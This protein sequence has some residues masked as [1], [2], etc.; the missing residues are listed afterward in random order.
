MPKPLC[1][2]AMPFGKKLAEG[3][4]IDFDAVL[5][6]IIV[7]A[8]KAA[9]MCPLRADEEQAGGIIHKHMFERLLLCE[10]VICDLTFANANVFY[11]LGVRHAAK[12]F[13][14][15]LIAADAVRLPF[16]VAMMRTLPYSL[17]ESGVPANPDGDANKLSGLLTKFRRKSMTDIPAND[18]PLFQLLDDIKPLQVSSDKTDLF[19]EQVACTEHV[20]SRLAAARR[21]GKPALDE[22]RNSIGSM[23][24][25]ES[26]VAIDIMLSYRAI[27]DWQGMIDFIKDMPEQ[28]R[29]TVMVQEQ[30]GLALNRAGRH[31]QA[32]SILKDLIEQR[33]P[34]SET[35]GILGRVY[36]DQ[37]EEACHSGQA[38][39]ANALLRKAATTYRHGFETDWR[40]HYPGINAITL[41]ELQEPPDNERFK[42]IPVVRYSVNQRTATGNPDYWDWATLLELEILAKNEDA[43]SAALEESLAK[44]T[45]AFELET[46]RRNLRLIREARERREDSIGWAGELEEKLEKAE[47]SFS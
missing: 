4:S 29:R 10:Y 37:W 44:A 15:V 19:R 39:K 41:M 47:E 16:D 27:R 23:D 20:R 42:L 3:R 12:P 5:K 40:D 31:E 17:D 6:R 45:E 13:T 43:A 32:A 34:S 14:T 35:L 21:D 30:L 1:F 38:A 22:V 18:S 28:L 33:G 36:K 11:E 26:G 7:P 46:T 8:V 2:V 24:V 9:D 25:V